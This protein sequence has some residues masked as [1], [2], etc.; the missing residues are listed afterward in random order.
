MIVRWNDVREFVY[1][2]PGWSARFAE[3]M[4]GLAAYAETTTPIKQVV[5]VV[6]GAVVATTPGEP[7]LTREETS[8]PEDMA[9]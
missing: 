9:A 4:G 2:Y 7:L 8:P 5:T 3:V 1:D 6:I